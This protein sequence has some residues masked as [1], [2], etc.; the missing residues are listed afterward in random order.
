[1]RHRVHE[2]TNG[3]MLKYGK[4]FSTLSPFQVL[5]HSQGV[6][7]VFTGVGMV[8]GPALGGFLYSVSC[9]FTPEMCLKLCCHSNQNTKYS[10]VDKLYSRGNMIICIPYR[11]KIQM[12]IEITVMIDDIY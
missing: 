11:V 4:T 9:N 1:M 6:A 10:C 5:Y 7:E 8:T 12:Y 2:H 3:I